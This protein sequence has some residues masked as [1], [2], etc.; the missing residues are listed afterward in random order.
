MT[1][2]SP[3]AGLPG[4]NRR[5]C[6]S[7]YSRTEPGLALTSYNQRVVDTGSIPLDTFADALRVGMFTDDEIAEWIKANRL[8]AKDK[9]TLTQAIAD[10]KRGPITG[11][12][13]TALREKEGL[14]PVPGDDS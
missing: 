14:S 8:S 5:R 11:V 4:S 7:A 1:A 9:A 12:I 13:R 2:P 3:H 10:L 6:W